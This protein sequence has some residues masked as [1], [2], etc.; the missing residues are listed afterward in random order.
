[1]MKHETTQ[2]HDTA[3]QLQK[4]MQSLTESGSIFA[5]LTVLTETGILVLLKD[6]KGLDELKVVTKL[7]PD[8]LEQMLQILVKTGFLVNNQQS[9]HWSNGLTEM[10]NNSTLD[11]FIAQIKFI[12]RMNIE[13]VKAAS[14]GNLKPNWYQADEVIINSWGTLS[15]SFANNFILDDPRLVQRL[16]KP[17]AI[18]LDAGAG[19]ANIS[20][21][22]CK[23]YPNLTAVAIDCVEKPLVI[24]K[25]NIHAAGLTDR[26]KLRKTLLQN[27]NDKALYDVVW[28]PQVYYSDVDFLE[29]LQVIWHALKPSGMIYVGALSF[30]QEN[31]SN[32]IAQFNN[33]TYGSL[34]YVNN[35]TTSFANAGF[36]EIKTFDAS[37]KLF[38]GYS[39]VSAIKP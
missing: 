9:Y 14:T 13:F 3:A 32:L 30:D 39:L 10:I 26:I 36:I 31:L 25:Q 38:N 4:T 29:G 5:S 11:T 23:I 2:N 22:M 6:A 28:L 18:F 16:S 8:I 7:P 1:M 24:A 15:Q 34:R 21:Q 19:T 20:L 35:V 27:L 37:N 17:G 33:A 12:A